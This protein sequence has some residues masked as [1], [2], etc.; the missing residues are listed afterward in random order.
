MGM[1]KSFFGDRK[2]YRNVLAITVPIV[3][4]NFISN[5]V[6]MLDN[7]MVGRVGTSEMSGVAVA[8]QLFFVL[9]LCIFGAVAG[10]GIFG[11][12]YAGKGD[13]EGV[14][15]VFRFKVW[16]GLLLTLLGMAILYFFGDGLVMLYLKGEGSRES[17]A[18]SLLSA[19]SYT[20]VN[21]IGM[22]PFL[23]GQC[24]SCTL[25]ETGETFVPM[26]AGIVAV[27]VNLIFNYIFI[28]GH[29]GV[30]AMGVTGAAAATV[31]S[32]FVELGIMVVWTA[33]HTEKEPFIVGAFSGF[34]IPSRL[35][36]RILLKTTPLMLNETLWAAGTATLNQCYSTRGLDVVAA[37]NINSTFMGVFSVAHLAVGTAI[38]IILG[39]LLGRN[40]TEKARG[41]ARKLIT[42]AFLVALFCNGIWALTAK[43]IPNLYNTTQEVRQLA[44]RLMLA[45]SVSCL[46]DAL[47]NA[48]YFTLRSG[49]MV[50]ITLLFDSG[51]MWGL[52]VPLA[53]WLSRGTDLPVIPLYCI[54]QGSCLVKIM[55]GVWLVHRGKWA[56][57]I[58]GDGKPE[59]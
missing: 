24:Y 38:S 6:N 20:R 7:I 58:I 28:Y 2:F 22:I 32:R 10:A 1:L 40:E 27:A 52:Q 45:G 12:Q 26:V 41:E 34:Y 8:N 9:N 17:A 35:V 16:F 43:A 50:S 44:T 37:N 56:K 42:C 39:Q 30:P 19:R 53:L 13:H 33:R 46:I 31:L 18:L 11:A 21:L 25:R 29:L 4:Q 55:L 14:R 5:F 49:G 48:F 59:A 54:V 36:G 51:F 3:V 23:L 57:N 15:Y 47:I